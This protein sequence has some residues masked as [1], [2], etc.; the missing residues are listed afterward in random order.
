MND[1][2]FT[3]IE[4]LIVVLLTL[5]VTGA[6]FSVVHPDSA[7]AQTQPEALDMQQRA[8]VGA[9]ALLRDLAQAGAGANAGAEI[10]PCIGTCRLSC[11]GVSD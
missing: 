11:R 8:R 6:V 4:T 3:L 1:R 7:I 5:G 10:N 2:G 9:D